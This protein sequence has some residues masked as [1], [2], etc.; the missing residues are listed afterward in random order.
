MCV[1]LRRLANRGVGKT[2]KPSRSGTTARMGIDADCSS[3]R[4]A[5]SD[6]PQKMRGALGA[7]PFGL[8]SPAARLGQYAWNQTSSY[9]GI[10]GIVGIFLLPNCGAAQTLGHKL[11]HA[12][13][14][15]VL[16]ED[17]PPDTIQCNVDKT[18][19]RSAIDYPFSDAHFTLNTM[20]TTKNVV[21]Y[22]RINSLYFPNVDSCVSNIFIEAS[23]SQ[24]VNLESTGI[25][26]DAAQI[27]LWH[28]GSIISSIRQY[29][30]EQMS[31][32]VEGFAKQ[33]VTDW[34][35]DN[36]G[37]FSDLVPGRSESRAKPMVP[38]GFVA[39]PAAKLP[40][41]LV[42]GPAKQKLPEGFSAKKPSDQPHLN[43]KPG[44]KTTASDVIAAESEATKPEATANSEVVTVKYRGPVN[45]GPFKC[46]AITRSSFIERVCYDQPNSYMLI[47]LSGTW[48][49]YCE[50][51]P[52]TVS[53]LMV[54]DSMGRFYNQSIKGR[55]D[56]G[57][58]RVP[59]Y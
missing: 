11:R 15:F 25:T 44:A 8:R 3:D 36:Y 41:G 40:E 48:Y 59:Q 53:N 56:C 13:D 23:I 32:S 4:D 21:F 20:D 55:F 27:K 26:L 17:L 2:G 50:I 33:F 38:D 51:D 54:A 45:L 43:L 29:H 34:N 24:T 10:L 16:I 46:D 37:E 31:A 52:D 49:H 5:S 35:L 9:L 18:T 22:V 30:R 57:T 6:R 14:V 1:W 42:A 58:H 28:A 7:F 12:K 47:E 19:I 39:G